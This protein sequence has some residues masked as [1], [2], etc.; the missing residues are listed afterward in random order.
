MLIDG[1]GQLSV[2]RPPVSAY[3]TTWLHAS[4]YRRYQTCC[5]STYHP[6]KPNSPDVVSFIFNCYKNQRLT[7]CAPSSFSRSLA[8]DINFVNLDSA[9]Q[10]I[11]ARP[12]HRSA[13]LMKPYPYGFVSLKPQYSLESHGTDSILLANY[14]PNRS[15]PK[16]KRFSC[17]L[18]NGPCRYRGFVLTLRAMVQLTTGYPRLVMPTTG[19]SKT[20]GPSKTDYI[21][22][23]RLLGVKPFFKFHYRSWVV[24]HTHGS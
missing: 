10:A 9:R 14:V 22:Q 5:R 4:F 7:G 16:L 3:D 19:T 11:S 20:I 12:H 8:A 15:K 18:K 2:A 17:I 6:T 21:F 24:F 13:K 1:R 23:A